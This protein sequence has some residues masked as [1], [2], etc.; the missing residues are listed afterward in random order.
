MA[1]NLRFFL[2][3]LIC[4]KLFVTFFNLSRD[5]VVDQVGVLLFSTPDLFNQLKAL[6][7]LLV[8]VDLVHF[9]S[10]H[11]HSPR[12]VGS[13]YGLFDSSV[14]NIC[15]L[16]DADEVILVNCRIDLALEPDHDVLLKEL[17]LVLLWQQLE[18]LG[19]AEPWAVWLDLVCLLFHEVGEL[20]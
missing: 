5:N 19:V 1:A 10:H 14:G 9:V 16:D 18:V 20:L 13:R 15:F 4:T 17:A 6:Q 2:E 12:L 3:D 8:E 7:L 11:L